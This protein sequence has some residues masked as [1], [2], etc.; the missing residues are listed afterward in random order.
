MSA[1]QMTGLCGPGSDLLSHA[2]RR[3]TI[4]A[5]AFHGRVRDGIGWGNAAI[6]TRSWQQMTEGQTRLV[7]GFV[8]WLRMISAFCSLWKPEDVIL[9]FRGRGLSRFASGEAVKR[10]TFEQLVRLSFMHY[11]TSTHRL[12]TWWS[13]TALK[14][15]LVLRGASRLDAFSGYPFRI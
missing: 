5:G 1:R 4:G 7:T 3:S 14:R 8:H 13:S 12:S 2:L 11:C 10:K 9:Q 15:D 6:A